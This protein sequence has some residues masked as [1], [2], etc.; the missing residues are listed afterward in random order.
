MPLDVL[1]GKW[2][3]EPEDAELR[4]ALGGPA[5]FRGLDRRRDIA[6]HAP[7]FVQVD[8][9]LHRVADRLAGRGHGGE[10]VVERRGA[11]PDLQGPEAFFAA[12]QRRLGLLGGS[13]A[14]AAR[15]VGRHALGPTP[16]ERRDRPV[17]RLTRQVPEGRLER[18]V[19]ARMECD[20]LE[21][22][23]VAFEVERVAADEQVLEPRES[24]HGVARADSDEALVRLHADE[25]RLEAATG[26]GIP[27]GREWRVEREHQPLEADGRNPH[28][29]RKTGLAGL[30]PAARTS[31]SAGSR[32]AA[33]RRASRVATKLFSYT[34]SSSFAAQSTHTAAISTSSSTSFVGIRP[35]ATA[36]AT[37][38]ATPA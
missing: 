6:R 21:R 7:P 1:G 29:R 19:A 38:R 5:R 30:A 17:L 36:V 2:L 37:P 34:V 8:D 25:R 12:C 11:D 15:R 26:L 22:A 10:P 18:P 32:S 4:Q 14:D 9:D 13:A 35:S 3:L 23:D 16:E 33:A 28:E 24:V 27:G 31:S 20:R